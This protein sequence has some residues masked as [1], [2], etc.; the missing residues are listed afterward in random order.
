MPEF[1][2]L[3]RK[4]DA[5]DSGY[6]AGLLLSVKEATGLRLGWYLKGVND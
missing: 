1:L 4:L 3:D 2:V 5:L 6:T